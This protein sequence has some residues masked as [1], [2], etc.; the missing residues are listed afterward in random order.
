MKVF[1]ALLLACTLFSCAKSTIIY[2]TK[3]LPGS[4]IIEENNFYIFEN[5]TVKITYSFWGENGYLSYTFYN[6]LNI[7]IYIDWKKCAFIRNGGKHDYW[8]DEVKGVINTK[9]VNYKLF[10]GSN[11]NLLQSGSVSASTSN[12]DEVK[13]ER[14]IFL[15]PKSSFTRI[16]A[17]HILLGNGAKV[18][19][20]ISTIKSDKG[21][22]VDM[23]YLDYDQSN[24]PVIFRNFMSISTTEN[25]EKE[26]YIDNGFYVDKKVQV[27]NKYFNKKVDVP[28]TNF[29]ENSSHFINPKWFYI[30]IQ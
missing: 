9:G 17:F 26:Y 25:F 16:D 12:S 8:R 14:V 5:D 23:T 13:P 11:Y 4:N 15:S 28:E 24:T 1:Y 21:K 20:A 18:T 3:P 29:Y 7:P 22:D 2:Q 10:F 6:K 30:S 19:G 27:N